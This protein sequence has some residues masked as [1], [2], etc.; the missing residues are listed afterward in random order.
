MEQIY[1]QIQYCNIYH[2]IVDN[3]LK[4]S[5]VYVNYGSIVNNQPPPPPPKK[6]HKLSVHL[7]V[8]GK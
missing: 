6:K 7:T 3:N 5:L 2:A 8:E 4:K 1:Y